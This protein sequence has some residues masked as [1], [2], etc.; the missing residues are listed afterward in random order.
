M[1]I[2]NHIS[3]RF[4]AVINSLIAAILLSIIPL[5]INIPL[6]NK[7]VPLW[8][9]IVSILFLMAT[10]L[11][12]IIYLITMPKLIFYI[13]SQFPNKYHASLI[14]NVIN[15]CESHNINV[16]VM[17]PSTNLDGG[18]QTK[19]FDNILKHKIFFI[20]GIIVPANLDE[21]KIE[22]INFIESF[23]KPVLFVDAPPP[24]QEIEYPKNSSFIGC[25][26]FEGGKLAANAMCY[27]LTRLNMP[28]YHVLIIATKVVTDRQK[29]FKERLNEIMSQQ[30]IY[31]DYEDGGQF[32]REDGAEIYRTAVSN[33][34]SNYEYYQGIFCTND[35]MALGVLDVM[36]RKHVAKDKVIIIGY[37]AMAEAK[38]L[39][40]RDDTHFKNS[41][42]QNHSKLPSR[43]INKLNKMIKGDNVSPK[44]FIKPEL[45]IQSRQ[46]INY[47]N[48]VTPET[49]T[50]DFLKWAGG[51][52]VTLSIVFTDIVGYTA[53]RHELGDESMNEILRA[54][55][56]QGRI[57]IKKFM[58]REIKTIG[59]S[60]M[61]AFHSVV[62]SLDFALAFKANTGHMQIQIRAGIHIGMLQ[63]KGKD[64]LGG[65]VDFAARVVGAIKGAEIWLS[66]E[67]KRDIKQLGAAHH[68]QLEW[69]RHEDI[70]MKGFPDK[71]ILWSLIQ[72][73]N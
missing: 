14:Q 21:H 45:V 1:K 66:D 22:L 7:S 12:L 46:C 60:F 6:F 19:W 20:G 59:D 34:G 71:R 23:K 38:E 43:S 26:N 55:F 5:I 3:S 40:S 52:N 70:E 61:V 68:T 11:S 17:F 36:D 32:K 25:D 41:V 57:F 47:E 49:N 73:S 13:A 54:H 4:S 51:K 9:L 56:A 48:I 27:E 8:V 16:V 37:D 69:K 15:Q 29:G 58:G 50:E 64:A 72:S 28:N 65:T 24:F 33:H 30:K 42:F 67:A 10:I 39:I 44:E 31:I 18:G 63:V 62:E 53:L 35:E 2:T